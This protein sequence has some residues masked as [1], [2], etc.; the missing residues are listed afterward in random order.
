MG[1]PQGW[2]DDGTGMERGMCS[3]RLPAMDRSDVDLLFDTNV[4]DITFYTLM[5]WD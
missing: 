5:L 2:G 3:D 1:I 4:H